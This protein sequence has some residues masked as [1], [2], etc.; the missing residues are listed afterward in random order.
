MIICHCHGVNDATIADAVDEGAC[1][2]DE[3]AE[4][5]GSGG[6][7]GGC[8]PALAS[9]VAARTGQPVEQAYRI[10]ARAGARAGARVGARV[11]AR[12]GV[13]VG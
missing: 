12:V 5:C 2:L 3:L 11:E 8:R 9:L 13:G 4:I 10:R 6:G 1:T 7:C